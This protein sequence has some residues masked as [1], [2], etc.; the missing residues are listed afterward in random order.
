MTMI[1]DPAEEQVHW[2]GTCMVIHKYRLLW[3]TA[4]WHVVPQ[5]IRC[6]LGQLPKL[7]YIPKVL[8]RGNHDDWEGSNFWL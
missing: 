2:T 3:R 1:N 4:V 8:T 6:S 7:S 5:F